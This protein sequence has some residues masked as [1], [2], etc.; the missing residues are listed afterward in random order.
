MSSREKMSV[1]DQSKERPVLGVLPP[2]G[3]EDSGDEGE[4]PPHM[5]EAVSPPQGGGSGEGGGGCSSISP[6]PFRS[7]PPMEMA[8]LSPP[9]GVPA[10][11]PVKVKIP[12]PPSWCPHRGRLPPRT[13]WG[14]LLSPSA[15]GALG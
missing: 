5:G 14:A 8:P 12:H 15:D 1:Q 10:G 13:A 11:P 2:P 7:G 4:T 3:D 6:H 9:N